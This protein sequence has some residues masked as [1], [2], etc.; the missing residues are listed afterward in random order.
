MK[1]KRK[2]NILD[3]EEEKVN[4]I[5]FIFATLAAVGAFVVVIG[6]L[7]GPPRDSRI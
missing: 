1:T 2:I 5:A 6:F 3:L 4:Q 7:D